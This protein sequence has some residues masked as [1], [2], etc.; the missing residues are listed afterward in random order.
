[1]DFE[2]SFFFQKSINKGI[3]SVSKDLP[4]F[5]QLISNH[6]NQKNEEKHYLMVDCSAKKERKV[7][8]KD[9]IF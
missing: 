3:I 5:Y 6:S 2:K 4:K 1:M 8:L 9:S 7:Q